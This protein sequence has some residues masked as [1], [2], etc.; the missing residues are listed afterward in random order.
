MGGWSFIEK[1]E[2]SFNFNSEH[3][4][5]KQQHSNLLSTPSCVL[6]HETAA[7][8]FIVCAFLCFIYIQ[9]KIST[10]KSTDQGI[11]IWITDQL[12]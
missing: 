6:Y 9:H 7:L 1:P 10:I 8:Q 12:K 3:W 11:W 5:M 2:G 4:I